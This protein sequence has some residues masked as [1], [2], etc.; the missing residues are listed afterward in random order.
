LTP[1]RTRGA[2]KVVAANIVVFAVLL[3]A[4]NGVSAIILHLLPARSYNDYR[5]YD[6]AKLVNYRGNPQAEQIFRDYA[7]VKYEFDPFVEWQPRP[8][9]GA[10]LTIDDAHFRVTPTP[11]QLAPSAPIVRFF[12]GST[13][14]GEGST[15]DGTIPAQFARLNPAYRPVNHGRDAFNTRQGLEQVTNLANEGARTDVAVF[16]EGTN[17]VYTMCQRDIGLNG[18]D[19]EVKMRRAIDQSRSGSGYVSIGTALKS[20]FIG[21]TRDLITR[22]QPQRHTQ[23]GISYRCAQDPAYARAVART[24]VANILAARRLVLAHGGRF[25]AVLQPDAFF[26]RPRVDQLGK[27]LYALGGSDLPAQ[28]KAVY[29]LLRREIRPYRQW[30]LDLSGVFDGPEVV[31]IDSAHVSPNG[32]AIVARCMS[33]FLGLPASGNVKAGG[34]QIPVGHRGPP[35]RGCPA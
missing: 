31:Y 1:V 22:L 27:K 13:M 25:M 15:N 33:A 26:G 30:F 10:T 2:I 11:R 12:G 28:Y 32:N 7:S 6:P 23:T 14:L 24:A 18:Q 29:P 34:S 17:D 16:Y 8:Y 35:A 21:S 4:V 19:Q 20:L 3:L 9:H 5:G